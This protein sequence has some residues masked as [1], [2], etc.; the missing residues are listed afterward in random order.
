DPAPRGC[1]LI[2]KI[3]SG[4]GETLVVE[5]I[6]ECCMGIRDTSYHS[7]SSAKPR[8]ISRRFSSISSA[9][10][11]GPYLASMPRPVLKGVWVL[12]AGAPSA[13]FPSQAVSV[14]PCAAAFA[15]SAA[16]CSSGISITVMDTSS[17]MRRPKVK[18]HSR[19]GGSHQKPHVQQ[20]IDRTL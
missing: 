3:T 20:R 10:G 9:E 5:Q 1:G 7:E 12:A 4:S 17:L 2:D 11:A 18:H 6:P 15:L 14:S 16:A 13:S 8:N 19:A